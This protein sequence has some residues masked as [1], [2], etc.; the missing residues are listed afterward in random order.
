[1]VNARGQN[2]QWI[3]VCCKQ[4]QAQISQGAHADPVHQQQWALGHHNW[5]PE[6]WWAGLIHKEKMVQEWF[7][8]HNHEFEVLT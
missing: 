2:T 7:D 8:E 1:M 4:A 3:A 6:Q 5:T